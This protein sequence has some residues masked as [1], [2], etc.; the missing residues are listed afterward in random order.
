MGAGGGATDSEMHVVD[1]MIGEHATVILPD[2]DVDIGIVAADELVRLDK[3]L[4]ATGEGHRGP[5]SARPGTC[6]AQRRLRPCCFFA[7]CGASQTNGG[8]RGPAAV[9]NTYVA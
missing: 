2:R 5:W 1:V 8:A 7:L 3:R 6:L 9:L 4:T